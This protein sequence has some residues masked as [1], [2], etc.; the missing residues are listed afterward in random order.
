MRSSPVE[1][2]EALVQK[3]ERNPDF[4]RFASEARLRD[5][6]LRLA[7]AQARPNI[8]VG[9]GVGRFNETRNT[10]IS[11]GFS[12]PLPLFDRNQGAIREAQVRRAQTDAQREA[13]FLRARAAVYGLY[14]ELLAS[15]T[16][17]E[18]LRKEAL[19]QAQQAL[20]QTQYGYERGRFSYLELATA[21]QEL[22]DVRAALIE[23]AANY[24]RVLA[25]IER[26]TNE[27]RGHR[28]RLAGTPMIALPQSVVGPAC[29]AVAGGCSKTPS[30][31]RRKSHPAKHCRHGLRSRP[32]SR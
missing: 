31:T 2:F 29:S 8:T 22:L 1:P 14:Q 12:M 28:C 9:V 6:E 16:A 26:L 23:A 3:L 27:P 21:Q 24:H 32:G 7:Q 25:E 19:P 18:T 11:A 13:A 20:D 10:G 30:V 5:A 15:R 17:P 4:V